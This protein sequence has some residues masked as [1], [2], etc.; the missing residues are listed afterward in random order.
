MVPDK[1]SLQQLGPTIGTS[2]MPQKLIDYLLADS[3]Q[4]IDDFSEN[5][6]G[7]IDK[8]LE[9]TL[10]DESSEY[11]MVCAKT[12]LK[13]S[14]RDTFKDV[15][16]SA[17]WHNIM[18]QEW[19]HNPIHWHGGCQLSSV[20]YLELPTSKD[21]GRIEF[22]PG[23]G[24]PNTPIHIDPVVGMFMIWPWHLQHSVAPIKG[25]T[26]TRRSFSINIKGTLV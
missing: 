12:M 3:K 15:Y 22:H 20:G 6:V 1:L 24:Y 8:Q 18:T 21:K 26:G 16:I 14:T 19:E 11:F 17:A 7:K 2:M 9:I 25:I 10:D 5:L 13:H 4:A 23:G